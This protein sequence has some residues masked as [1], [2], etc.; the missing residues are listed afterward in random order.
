MGW[1]SAVNNSFSWRLESQGEPNVGAR[2][3]D[4]ASVKDATPGQFDARVWF[5]YNILAAGVCIFFI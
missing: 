3:W 5:G 4:I 2:K 1:R